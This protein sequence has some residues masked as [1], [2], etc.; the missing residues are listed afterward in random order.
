[1]E[2]KTK[3]RG[4][5]IGR[6]SGYGCGY[7]GVPTE[8]PWYGKD[9]DQID[10]DVHGGLTWSADYVGGDP[11]DG[12]W[13][14]GFDTAHSEDNMVNCGKQYCIDQ[15]ESLKQQALKIVKICTL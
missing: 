14:I 2:I 15:I 9:Y 7:V 4:Y 13:W 5:T 3:L 11:K 10:A 12:Y 1:M 8:H 6:K